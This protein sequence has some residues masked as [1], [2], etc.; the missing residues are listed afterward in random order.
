MSFADLPKLG[1]SIIMSF[2]DYER[3]HN[4]LLNALR[5]RDTL[6][7]LLS[8]LVEREVFYYRSACLASLLLF[9]IY[10]A[11][12]PSNTNYYNHYYIYFFFKN[13]L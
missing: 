7:D 8:Y 6:K 2:F 5:T 10:A 9:F 12:F 11:V 13:I 4:A 1:R 3:E